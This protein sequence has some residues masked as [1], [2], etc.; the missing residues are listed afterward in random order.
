MWGDILY[1]AAANVLELFAYYY[2][3]VEDGVI[4]DRFA[5]EW[6]PPRRPG[7]QPPGVHYDFL[8]PE[9]TVFE[10]IEEEKWE[11]CRGI[12]NSFGYN[13]MDDEESY[14]TAA[15]VIQMFVDIVSKNGNLLLNVGPRADG[16]I[17]ELQ[18]DCLLG[19]G[20][21]M[22]VNGEAI[23]GTRPWVR[24]AST[25]GNGVDVRFTQ[26]KRSLYAI[27]LGSPRG[28]TVTLRDVTAV[29]GSSASLLGVEG[30][31]EWSQEGDDLTVRL[32][33]EMPSQAAYALS[34][35]PTVLREWS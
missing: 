17:H 23:R 34:I 21:W 16:S 5:T 3:R 26:K 30:N 24:A 31:L 9:Y 10:E 29:P 8:T 12:S 4:N 18:R 1:P 22:E 14:L 32:P 7:L 19:L 20:R 6:T 15:Q 2:N 35:R 27:L 33:R 28:S 25:T 13:R 11:T